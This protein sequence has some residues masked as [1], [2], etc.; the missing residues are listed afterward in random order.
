MRRGA[1]RPSPP[2]SEKSPEDYGDSPE[3]SSPFSR[4]DS[5]ATRHSSTLNSPMSTG[6]SNFGTSATFASQNRW[7]TGLQNNPSDVKYADAYS[8]STGTS[9][10]T[11]YSTRGSNASSTINGYGRSLNHLAFDN[12]AATPGFPSSNVRSTSASANWQTSPAGY[13]VKQEH[14]Y[15]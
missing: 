3:T 13:G 9:G 5:T 7:M 1:S 11:Q 4:R 15:Q 12:N 8:N 2:E 6:M 14:H 10:N